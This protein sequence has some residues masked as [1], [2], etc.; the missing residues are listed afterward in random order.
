M[1]AEVRRGAWSD[2]TRLARGSGGRWAL[3]V[4]AHDHRGFG[5]AHSVE[6][7]LHQLWRARQLRPRRRETRRRR[8]LQIP[9]ACIDGDD[10]GCIL[11]A[12]SHPVR[13]PRRECEVQRA[14]RRPTCGSGGR[15]ISCARR[16]S[17]R[18]VARRLGAETA[19]S[20]SAAA[21]QMAIK[22]TRDAGL[23]EL[24]PHAGEHSRTNRCE[25]RRGRAAARNGSSSNV[26]RARGARRVAGD[27]AARARRAACITGA[28][29][30]TPCGSGGRPRSKQT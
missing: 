4:E 12:R 19:S 8:L 14:C 29:D 6:V 16:S 27:R 15:S 18:V 23:A 5:V 2:S 24:E 10:H 7:E 28:L 17:R 21:A 30:R 3:P 26:H 25:L 22:R 1:R 13:Q 9:R 11:A 20:R